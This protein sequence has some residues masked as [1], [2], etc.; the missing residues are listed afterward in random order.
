MENNY[1]R[2][3]EKSIYTAYIQ[4]DTAIDC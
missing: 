2:N 3:S 4:D 1:I